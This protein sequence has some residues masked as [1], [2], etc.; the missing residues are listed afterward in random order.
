MLD[1]HP[2]HAVRVA[3]EVL[4]ALGTPNDIAAAVAAWLVN[5]DLSGHP[6]HGII[7]LMDYARRMRKGDLVPTGR[8][9]I[10][11]GERSGPVV[12]V[13]GERGY[14]H[15]AARE[16]VQALVQRTRE[17]AVAV[18]GVVN[19]SHTGRLG[20]W[21]ELAA[22]QGV[23]LMMCSASLSRGNVAAY[24]A[25]EARLGTNPITVGV[26]AADGDSFV[27]D[28]AT[29]EISG[30][31]LDYLVQAGREAPPDALLDADG[32][33]TTDPSDW[34]A[35]GMLL[36]FGGHKGY[37]FSLLVALLAG[38][39]VGRAAPGNPRHGVFAFAVDP[40][41]FAGNEGVLDAISEQLN[42]MRSTP[43][44][45]GFDRVEVPGDFERRN[46]AQ[47]ATALSVPEATWQGI[48][49]LGESLGLAAAELERGFGD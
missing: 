10:V 18:G 15:L 19:A 5:S 37:G 1:V 45:H 48:L 27:L 2:R 40:T 14:G 29:S 6:S 30:G 31:K 16:L 20:E 7:R 24:G 34:K 26:P 35:G 42:R 8:P 49:A 21:S 28:F 22:R 9:R 44:R 17:S 38:C 32:N 25:R 36:P 46:R 12:L 3:D 39:I 33:A 47:H 13:D 23:V 41:V 43:P 11:Q 4:H